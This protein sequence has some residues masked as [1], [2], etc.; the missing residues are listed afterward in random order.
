MFRYQR[1]LQRL[2]VRM[3]I[4]ACQMRLKMIGLPE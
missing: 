4:A 2:A 3:R 1:H